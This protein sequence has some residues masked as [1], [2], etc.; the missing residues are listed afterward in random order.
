MG[1][2][3]FDYLDQVVLLDTLLGVWGEVTDWSAESAARCSSGDPASQWK[4]QKFFV[5]LENLK[6]LYGFDGDF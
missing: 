1:R 3:L 4:F 2:S 5:F 6:K